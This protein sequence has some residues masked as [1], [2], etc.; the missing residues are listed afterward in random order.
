MLSISDCYNEHLNE[1]FFVD[2]IEK[3]G[4]LIDYL[5]IRDKAIFSRLIV[6]AK[7]SKF[8]VIFVIILKK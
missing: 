3:A 2:E 4:I 6:K 1:F 5:S 8:V 7:K